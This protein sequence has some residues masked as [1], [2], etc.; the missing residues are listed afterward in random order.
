MLTRPPFKNDRFLKLFELQRETLECSFSK[1]EIKNSVWRCGGDKAPGPD[2]FTFGFIK[3][4]WEIIGDDIMN[5]VIHFH[6]SAFIPK[7]GITFGKVN[8]LASLL[9]CKAD[10]LPFIYL[11]LPIGG[12]MNTVNSKRFF[13][14]VTGDT[15][16]IHWVAWEKVLSNKK[17]GGL[18]IR[19]LEATK[20]ALLSKWWWRFH[21]EG[22]SLW[23]N[24]IK[25]EI[26]DSRVNNIVE[27]I[28]TG[29]IDIC[30]WRRPPREGREEEELNNLR[31]EL[32][33]AE[34]SNPVDCL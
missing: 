6:S 14:G 18:G 3:K 13:W 7:G 12:N 27:H 24:V 17:V 11:G 28:L 9:K 23:E 2:G 10:S 15:R 8:S 25:E 22:E 5:A 30:K 33:G 20:L 34:F 16:K 1:Q 29:Q 31:L 32:E 21:I 19:S 4:Y 26:K